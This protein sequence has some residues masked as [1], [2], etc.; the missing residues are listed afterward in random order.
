MFPLR[1]NPIPGRCVVRYC[2]RARHQHSRYCAKHIQRKWRANHPIIAMWRTLQDNA[3]RRG[4][5]FTLTTS[6]FIEFLENTS[7][8]DGRG[9]H[10]LCLHID[11]KDHKLGYTRG[12]IQTLTCS[13]NSTKGNREKAEKGLC[14]F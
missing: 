13:E 12:N 4:K 14:P 9:R 1:A 10:R 3:K 11:R 2:R 7:Y 5:E 8:V 6:D